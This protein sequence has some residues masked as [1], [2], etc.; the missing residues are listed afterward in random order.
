MIIKGNADGSS[1]SEISINK[2][3][4]LTEDTTYNITLDNVTR[5]SGQWKGAFSIY[6]N[7]SGKTLT[8]YITLVGE[9]KSFAGNHGGIKLTGASGANINV[10]FRTES[11]GSLE[12]DAQY[13]NINDLQIE[14]VTVNFSIE[15]GTTF[16]SGTSDGT[17]YSDYNSFFNAAKNSTSGSKF[18]LSTTS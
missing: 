1:I 5:S 15:S 17:T 4:T 9:N 14:N 6:N 10:V 8:V 12:F 11:S 7:T 16:E 2:N 18:S 13:S 3:V